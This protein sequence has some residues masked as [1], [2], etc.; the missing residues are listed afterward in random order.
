VTT[1]TPMLVASF[2]AAIVIGLFVPLLF[3]E[4]WITSCPSL[5]EAGNV[6]LPILSAECTR[7]LIGHTGYFLTATTAFVV[8]MLVL[9]PLGQVLAHFFSPWQHVQTAVYA[10]RV[11]NI[12]VWWGVIYLLFQRVTNARRT[13]R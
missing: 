9:F 6:W 5:S 3:R 2:L 8:E 11:V 10:G 7:E 1:R 4:I 13:P 12:L